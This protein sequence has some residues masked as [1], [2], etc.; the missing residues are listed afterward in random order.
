MTAGET[1]VDAERSVAAGGETWRGRL[2]A[3]IRLHREGK[4]PFV[5]RDAAFGW[6]TAW[7]TVTYTTLRTEAAASGDLAVVVGGYAAIAAGQERGSYVRVWKRDATGRW[8]IVFE[9]SK[10]RP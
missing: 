7:E 1:I 6:A 5:G 8:R 10:P 4:M 2:A 9:T 3:G